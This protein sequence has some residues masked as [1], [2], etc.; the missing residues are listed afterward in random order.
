MYIKCALKRL[1]ISANVVLN[2]G[3]SDGILSEV[4][5]AVTNGLE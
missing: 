2:V 4:E 3:N 5:A 1:K